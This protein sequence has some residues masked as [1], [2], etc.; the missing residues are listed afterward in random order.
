MKRR[1][2][3]SATLAASAA[4]LADSLGAQEA[5]R[6]KISIVRPRQF[7]LL[8]RYQLETGSQTSLVERYIGE[9]LIPAWAGRGAVGAFK[10][11]IGPKTP[12]FYV[13]IPE[14]TP[15]VLAT[16]DDLLNANAD[17]KKAAE[18]FLNAPAGA[19]AFV[20]MESSLLAAFEGWPRLTPPDPKSRRIFQLRTYESPS[21]HDHAVKIAMFHSG[22]FEIFKASGF[23][24]VF[25]GDTLIG[26]RMPSL[27]YMLA[28]DDLEHLTECWDKFRANPDWNKLS[29]D[30]RFA[31]EPIVSNITNLVLSPLSCSQI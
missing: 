29:N 27:T 11:E 16:I 22:E 12:A 5:G 21:V 3:L 31:Y 4:G 13:L 28:F 7:Y 19:P 17:Y 6:G 20:R 15:G 1:E 18:P 9:A 25:F 30:P 2:F 24:P 14:F 23:R 26:A 10:V 8:Q